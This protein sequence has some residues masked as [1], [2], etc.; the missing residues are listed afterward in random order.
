LPKPALGEFLT[1]HDLSLVRYD[2]DWNS[3]NLT[4]S[5]RPNKDL[6]L[7]LLNKA[8]S[9]PGCTVTVNDQYL[10]MTQCEKEDDKCFLDANDLADWMAQRLV[11]ENE[12]H[13]TLGR[14]I[15]YGI[16]E[17]FAATGEGVFFLDLQG[18][19]NRISLSHA[20]SFLWHEKLPIECGWEPPKELPFPVFLYRMVKMMRLYR[21][22]MGKFSK[23]EFKDFKIDEH[24][25]F[26]QE[27]VDELMKDE[28]IKKAFPSVFE[29]VNQPLKKVG[30][31]VLLDKYK[32]PKV[33]KKIASSD[34]L[35]RADKP[36]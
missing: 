9:K 14:P 13:K 12:R 24:R 23:I 4:K 11:E 36:Q 1:E 17:E 20:K 2:L 22:K 10:A 16:N 28:H 25:E 5:V 31:Q 6:V 8:A 19:N 33:L 15:T 3:Y 30:S 29:A 32:E 26:T 35:K 18:R 27:E 21:S 34:A 7:G